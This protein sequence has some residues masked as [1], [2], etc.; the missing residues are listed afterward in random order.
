MGVTQQACLRKLKPKALTL[1]RC[2]AL[3]WCSLQREFSSYLV[4]LVVLPAVPITPSSML[5]L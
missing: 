5:R 2:G 3:T 4:C 1:R